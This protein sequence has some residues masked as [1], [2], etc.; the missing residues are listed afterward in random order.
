MISCDLVRQHPAHFLACTGLTVAEF[1]ALLP[2]FTRAW[3][4]YRKQTYLNDGGGKPKL[5]T[6]TDKLFFILFYYK[7]YPIQSAMGAIF[8]ISQAQVCVWIH[9]L[10]PVLRRA[11]GIEWCLPERNPAKLKDVLAMFETLDFLIDGT[12]RERQRPINRRD[13]KDCYSGKKHTY[14]Y[15][16][17]VIVHEYDQHVVYLSQTYEGSW[18]DK[19]ICDEEEYTFPRYA[20]LQKDRGFQGFEP[21]HTITYQ[22][23]KKPKHGDLTIGE[24]L[25]NRCISSSRIAIEHAISGIK[26]CRIIK[27]ILRNTT[28]GF[29]D[30]V[31]EIACALHNFRQKFRVKE[32]HVNIFDLLPSSQ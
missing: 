22:P 14:T 29:E 16:N 11:L 7:V 12:E 28:L 21:D 3:E 23:K 1:D 4:E 17:I 20:T 32:E 19:A 31:M 15:N 9:T 2:A 27:D 30:T 6:C 24:K 26:R 8:G 10:S 18:H 5:P 13:R 25:F